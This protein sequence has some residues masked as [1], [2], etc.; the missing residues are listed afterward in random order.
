M[1]KK[2]L[3]LEDLK[4][5]GNAYG[6]AAVET[7]KADSKA[8]DSEGSASG[9]HGIETTGAK[10]STFMVGP[11]GGGTELLQKKRR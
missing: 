7:E 4:T 5:F 11:S 9:K 8:T 2:K 3:T 10:T 1:S 6:G